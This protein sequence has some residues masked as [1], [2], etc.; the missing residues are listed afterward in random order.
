MQ[1]PLSVFRFVY[2]Q[3]SFFICSSSLI[4]L[5]LFFFFCWCCCCFCSH[6]LTLPPSLTPS[7]PPSLPP[8]SLSLSLS[9]SLSHP[10][11]FDNR[12][13]IIQISLQHGCEL[14]SLTLST[15]FPSSLSMLFVA[16]PSHFIVSLNKCPTSTLFS[17]S[18]ARRAPSFCVEPIILITSSTCSIQS[19]LTKSHRRIHSE[20][21]IISPPLRMA[22]SLLALEEN[23]TY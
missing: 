5:F 20:S 6:S 21:S 23:N 12:R 4:Y 13:S 16:A 8:P 1:M 18:P 2:L 19:P 7:R 11:I 17:G 14:T 15:I 22:F 10:H 3:F 9:L